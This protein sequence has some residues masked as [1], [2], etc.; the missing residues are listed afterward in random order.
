M[1]SSVKFDVSVP[2]TCVFCARSTSDALLG[3]L[4]GPYHPEP[5]SPRSPTRTFSPDR[6]K[7]AKVRR[8]SLGSSR[9]HPMKRLVPPE[10]WLHEDCAVWTGGVHF[11]YGRLLGLDDAISA[12]KQTT[13]CACKMNGAS[14]GCLRKGCVLKYHFACAVEKDCQLDEDNFSMVCPKHKRLAWNKKLQSSE[15]ENPASFNSVL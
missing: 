2:W 6:D 10:I 7:P 13:C 9:D 11:S 4:Y 5:S 12:A 8:N 15:S 1:L 14:L 3:D